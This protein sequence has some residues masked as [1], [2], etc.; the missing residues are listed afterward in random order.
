MNK[1]NDPNLSCSNRYVPCGMNV[2]T[3][4]LN[5]IENSSCRAHTFRSETSIKRNSSFS[6]ERAS[7]LNV[8]LLFS[9]NASCAG[10]STPIVPPLSDSRIRELFV[11]SVRPSFRIP[12]HQDIDPLV[13]HRAKTQS[14]IEPESTIKALD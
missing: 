3:V 2:S 1:S 10:N 4:L 12:L 8:E 5:V 11:Y 6:P 7:T 9:M 13:R 14:L